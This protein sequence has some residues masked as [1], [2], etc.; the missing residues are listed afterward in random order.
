VDEAWR[1]FLS[2]I[3]VVGQMRIRVLL[4]AVVLGV[5]VYVL[6][7]GQFRQDVQFV[8][9]TYQVGPAVADRVDVFAQILSV[10]GFKDTIETRF[11]FRPVGRFASRRNSSSQDLVVYLATIGGHQAIRLNAGEPI[12]E[13]NVRRNL[14][15]GHPADYPF[16][17]YTSQIGVQVF[18][19]A[20]R[21]ANDYSVPVPV[22]LHY[23]EDL[24][25]YAVRPTVAAGSEAGSLVIDLAMR[26]SAA[27]MT[28]ATFTFAAIVLI[29]LTVFAV[30]CL[31]L[32]G[33]SE[34]DFGRMVWS[35]AMIFALPAIRN[36]LPS[37]PPIGIRADF[38]VLLWAQTLVALSMVS[39][40]VIWLSRQMRPAA[41]A[42]PPSDDGP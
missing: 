12:G 31:T 10:S 36:S 16:D 17:A 3:E 40:T 1:S 9:Q 2:L 33:K 6:M 37:S 26:R 32:V 38:Y 19:K 30:A 11:T 21:G 28:F 22:V 15:N 14:A 42:S 23:Q 34:P 39:M 27:V 41:P 4:F 5:V 8:Q 25:G 18:R 7:L 20:S 13:F 35:G 24:I 29:A